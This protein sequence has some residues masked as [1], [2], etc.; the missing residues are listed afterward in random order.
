MNAQR[1]ILAPVERRQPRRLCGSRLDRISPP[2]PDCR[3]VRLDQ[4]VGTKGE[5]CVPGLSTPCNSVSPYACTNE[6]IDCDSG[7]SFDQCA[8]PVCQDSDESSDGCSTDGFNTY[9]VSVSTCT[10]VP[11]GVIDCDSGGEHCMYTASSSYTVFTGCGTTTICSTTTG[12][13]CQ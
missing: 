7:N 8:D 9:T 13:T 5:C 6:G 1:T 3:N 12:P 10:V 2:T 4:V 11:G